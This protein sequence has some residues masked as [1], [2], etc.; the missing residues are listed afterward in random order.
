MRLDW[1]YISL[2]HACC[3]NIIAYAARLC[4]KFSIRFSYSNSGGRIFGSECEPIATAWKHKTIAVLFPSSDLGD[5]RDTRGPYWDLIL[6]II[7]LEA[8]ALQVTCSP[9]FMRP[10]A[11]LWLAAQYWSAGLCAISTTL[12]N[13]KQGPQIQANEKNCQLNFRLASNQIWNS[14]LNNKI[15]LISIFWRSTYSNPISGIRFR[16]SAPFASTRAVN[17]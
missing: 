8:G 15:S 11:K 14:A 10:L 17:I 2:H 6:I 9:L 1:F 13:P 3:N 4:R 16:I 12:H 5:G 7:L